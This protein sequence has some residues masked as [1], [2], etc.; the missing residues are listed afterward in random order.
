M[1]FAALKYH[2]LLYF[3]LVWLFCD[4]IYVI[5]RRNNIEGYFHAEK[6]R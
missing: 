4:I 3:D 6:T 5:V 2:S 1:V